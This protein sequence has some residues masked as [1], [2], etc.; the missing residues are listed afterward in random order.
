MTGGSLMGVMASISE[1]QKELMD[2]EHRNFADVDQFQRLAI[3]TE[4]VG[5][6]AHAT[7]KQHQ[8]IRLET[9][10]DGHIK[11][12]LGDVFI[13]L[14]TFAGGRGWDLGEIVEETVRTVLARDWTKER[15]DG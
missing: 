2:W 3:I 5:E 13:T 6:L 4:E 9:A 1:M 10:T 14:C 8:G 7:L 15:G 11:D 12:A